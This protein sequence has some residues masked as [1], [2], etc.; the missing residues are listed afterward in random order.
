MCVIFICGKKRA[1]PEAIADA[2]LANG[3][4]AGAAWREEVPL[5]DD[6][7]KLDDNG[8]ELP[9]E[10]KVHWEKGLMKEEEIQELAARIPLPHVLHFRIPTVGG[11]VPELTH[12]FPVEKTAPLWL[13][14]TTGGAVL[15]HNGHWHSWKTWILELAKLS[16]GKIKVPRGYWS[17]SRAMAFAAAS[18]GEGV[19]EFIDEKICLFTPDQV[20]TFGAGWSFV[21]DMWVSNQSW[22]GRSTKKSDNYFMNRHGG[23]PHDDK[24]EPQSTSTASKGNR[25]GSVTGDSGGS[26]AIRS[27]RGRE[28]AARRGKDVEQ[29]VQK[30]AEGISTPGR[31][32]VEGVSP[33]SGGGTGKGDHP[34]SHPSLGVADVQW[35]RTLNPSPFRREL[36]AVSREDL[37]RFDSES[38]TFRGD[39]RSERVG[40]DDGDHVQRRL[41]AD[42]GIQRLGPM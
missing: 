9:P 34:A 7:P 31:G 15:F 30:G 27:F 37:A 36:P 33:G 32:G 4:G 3:S 39:D 41:E 6:G 8:K 17:D 5:D 20:A 16:G 26:S 38:G 23:H 42:L 10:I 11:A 19:L 29:S 24:E 40:K 2:F 35:V 21:Q 22:I 18:C 28:E 25:G 13:K 12:P 14:G 1:T